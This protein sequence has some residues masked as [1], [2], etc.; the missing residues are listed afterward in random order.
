[1]K[2]VIFILIF[3]SNMAMADESTLEGSLQ[4]NCDTK[5]AGTTCSVPMSASAIPLVVNLPGRTDGGTGN[6]GGEQ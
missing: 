2:K 6:T 1:M 3:V 4:I 5:V